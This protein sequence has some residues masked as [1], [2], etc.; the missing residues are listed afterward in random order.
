MKG[1]SIETPFIVRWSGEVSAATCRRPGR[2]SHW[3]RASRWNRDRS[4]CSIPRIRTSP[5]SRTRMSRTSRTIPRTSASPTSPTTRTSPTSPTSRTIPRSPTSHRCSTSPRMRSAR[6][7][8]SCPSGSCHPPARP[9]ASGYC[10]CRPTRHASYSD[11]WT[12]RR[13]ATMSPTGPAGSTSPSAGR[14]A[15]PIGSTIR[16]FHPDSPGSP[17]CPGY[18]GSHSGSRSTSPSS[19]RDRSSGEPPSP[20][21]AL[22][23]R[24]PHRIVRGCALGGITSAIC[25][26]L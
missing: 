9:T 1:V 19:C 10:C 7:A 18:L 12:D 26:R 25:Q 8:R 11:L 22:G 21:V 3:S 23:D 16:S 17:D 2:S 15:T 24:P 4:D 14:S 6:S 5:S 20:E 13:A